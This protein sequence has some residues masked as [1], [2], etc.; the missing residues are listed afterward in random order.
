MANADCLLD[1]EEFLLLY[2]INISKSLDLPYWQYPN[3]ELD[4]LS[5][6]EW[7]SELRFSKNDI[8]SPHDALGF[9]KNLLVIMD[10]KF[11]E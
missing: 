5:N 4:D 3:F 8:Y 11:V 7:K 9:Q 6:N 2:D 1:D 10:L